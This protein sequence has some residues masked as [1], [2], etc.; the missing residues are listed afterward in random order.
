MEDKFQE[1]L[2]LDK[3]KYDRL[4]TDKVDMEAMYDMK[5]SGFETQQGKEVRSC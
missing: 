3:A 2:T 1:E 5:V 4:M